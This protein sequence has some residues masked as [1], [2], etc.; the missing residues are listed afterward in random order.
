[1]EYLIENN[2][3][4]TEQEFEEYFLKFK[5]KHILEKQAYKNQLKRNSPTNLNSEGKE[6]ERLHTEDLL[7]NEELYL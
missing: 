2:E 7:M 1:M 5:A 4:C 3:D 6:E